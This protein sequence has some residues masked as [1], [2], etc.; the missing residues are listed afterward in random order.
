MTREPHALAES[1]SQADKRDTKQVW[2]MFSMA[3]AAGAKR[4]DC[5]RFIAAFGTHNTHPF[6]QGSRPRES[7]AEAGAVQ[8]LRD[9][10]SHCSFENTPWNSPSHRLLGIRPPS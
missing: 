9:F 4:L 1:C 5:A 2:S 6:F 7:A 10:A 3:A 8:T